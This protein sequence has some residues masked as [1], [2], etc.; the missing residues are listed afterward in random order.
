[1][2]TKNVVLLTCYNC[3]EEFYRGIHVKSG[4]RNFCSRE[5]QFESYK[6]SGNPCWRGGRIV[7]GQ[8]Y[9]RIRKPDH[10]RAVNGYVL[11]HILVME[12][13]IGRNIE[14][15]E[16][17]HH[18]NGNTQDNRPENLKLFSNNGKHL[19]ETYCRE[20]RC[21]CGRK[22]KGHGLCARHLAQYRRTG[23][24]WDF[25]NI[26]TTKDKEKQQCK[27]KSCSKI[28]KSRG[29]CLYHYRIFRNKCQNFGI[30]LIHPQ[31][32]ENF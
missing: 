31:S 13:K 32:R 26:N 18:I 24:V 5:C 27:I 21:K 30:K 7:T 3:G 23:N 4:K 28:S 14:S 11:E 29:Y 16:A 17:I 25:D 9:I 22:H 2:K 8:G 6:G 1:M 12:N 20:K 10:P 19:S 15:E